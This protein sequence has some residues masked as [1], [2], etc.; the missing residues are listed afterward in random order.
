MNHWRNWMNIGPWA[1][2]RYRMDRYW[3][4]DEAYP[5]VKPHVDHSKNL[6]SDAHR[7]RVKTVYHKLLREASRNPTTGPF[8]IF[9]YAPGR[10]FWEYPEYAAKIRY[11]FE[12][13]RYCTNPS[14]VAELVAKAEWFAYEFEHTE[15]YLKNPY[16]PTGS[17][18]K[19]NIVFPEHLLDPKAHHP[20]PTKRWPYPDDHGSHDH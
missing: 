5:I 12:E 3:G 7:L 16:S 6:F 13:N 19:R 9:N 2:E 17:A 20:M 1:K 11:K 8:T 14:R 10:Q 18:W 15:P 4:Q